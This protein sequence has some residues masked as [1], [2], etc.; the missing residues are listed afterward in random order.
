[1]GL[2]H[3]KIVCTLGPA[4]DDVKAIGALIDA[5]MDVARLN[6]SHGTHEEHARRI[7]TVRA[8]IARARKAD[9]GAAGPAGPE[10]PYRPRLARRRRPTGQ[11]M[12]LVGGRRR[13]A[14]ARSPSNTPGWRRICT[15]GDSCASTT[16]GSRCA[17][18]EIGGRTRR[19][20]R[21][22]GRRAARSHGRAPALE[23]RAAAGADREGP[24]R[25]G[26]RAGAGRRLR[27][28]VVREARG[29]RRWRCA[30]PARQAGRPTP[31]VAKIE[32]PEAIDNL[33]DV[34]AASDAVMVARGDLGVELSPERVPVVQKEI[35]G[36]LPAAADGR[37]SSRPRCCSRWSNRRGRRAPRPATWRRRCSTA[38]TR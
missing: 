24:P 3:A 26:A 34:V 13:L 15:P 31:I 4:T 18:S 16:G 21:S 6:F 27:R 12:T 38:P 33:W 23:A 36:T 14:T 17:W 28:A 10:D 35:I 11:T 2:R 8:R 37:S 32:T 20:R 29:R 30:R 25:P 1:M 7:A 5:G 19:V 9:R 22:P